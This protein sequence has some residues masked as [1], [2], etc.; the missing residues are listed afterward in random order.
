MGAEAR[1]NPFSQWK[2]ETGAT[3]FNVYD[4]FGRQIGIGDMI[5]LPEVGDVVWRVT[6]VRPILDPKAPPGLCHLQLAA[7]IMEGVQGGA[8]L[9]NIVKV[10]DALEYMTPEMLEKAT[11]EMRG[12]APK[13]EPPADPPADNPPAPPEAPPGLVTLT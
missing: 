7:V 6:D 4:R 5:T 12:E 9:A 8:P 11:A 13:E 10:R 1:S 2:R 3:I